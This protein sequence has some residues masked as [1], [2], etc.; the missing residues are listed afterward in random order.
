[1]VEIMVRLGAIQRKILI[2]LAGGIALSLSHNPQRQFKILSHMAH[3]WSEVNRQSLERAIRSLYQSKLVDIREK[4]HGSIVMTLNHDGRKKVLSYKLDEM[5]IQRPKKWDCKWRIVIFDIPE[6][7]KKAREAMRY[8]LQRLGFYKLQKSVFVFPYECQDEIEFLVEFYNL[9]PH[10][11]R[12]TA[13]HIDNEF[14]L[15]NIFKLR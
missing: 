3:G 1:M 2:L 6:D 8:H 9:Q 15:K 12:I 4:S 13:E 14:H 11:R 7:F 10:V 5:K